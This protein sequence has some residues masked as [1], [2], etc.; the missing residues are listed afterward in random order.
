MAVRKTVIVRRA[1][2]ADGVHRHSYVD[3]FRRHPA[4]LVIA[5][6]GL[7][8]RRPERDLTVNG[9]ECVVTI[10]RSAVRELRDFRPLL[11]ADIGAAL[12]HD[13][14]TAGE[15]RSAKRPEVLTGRAVGRAEGFVANELGVH[16]VGRSTDRRRAQTMNQR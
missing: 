14:A 16:G 15:D 5:A 11:P 7:A 1:T 9:V 4:V 2:A 3:A 8:H 12:Q 10:V 13:G 6:V